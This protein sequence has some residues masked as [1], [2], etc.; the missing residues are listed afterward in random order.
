MRMDSLREKAVEE[1]VTPL[2]VMLRTMRWA[3]KEAAPDGWN[4]ISTAKANYAIEIAEKAAPYVHARF[5]NHAV[6]APDGAALLAA[7]QVLIYLP[8]NGRD[9]ELTQTTTIEAVPDPAPPAK[10]PEWKR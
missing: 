7:P 2:E 6:A 1:G 8:D 9:P 10:P 4:V 3:W 5:M